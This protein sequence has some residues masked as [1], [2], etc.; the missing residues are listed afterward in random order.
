MNFVVAWIAIAIGLLTGT[1]LGLFFHEESWLGGY[2]SWRRRL[3]RLGHIS[4][5]GTG[6]L[7]LAFV[8]SVRHLD[9]WPPPPIAASGFALGA[10]AM[11]IICFLSAWRAPFR[12]FFFIPV[13]SLIVAS[14]DFLWQGIFG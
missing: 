7:N 5:F 12:R 10:L 1:V 14:A 13:G 8:L 11:P 4:F 3:V 2:A 9:L 6:F